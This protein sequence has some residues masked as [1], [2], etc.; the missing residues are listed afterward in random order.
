MHIIKN[1][2]GNHL[3]LG[4][5]ENIID[6][7]I[8]YINN[9]KIVFNVTQKKKQ[10]FKILKKK[11]LETGNFLEKQIDIKISDSKQ[12]C[13]M[14]LVF[15]IQDLKI[16]NPRVFGTSRFFYQG[17]HE[18]DFQSK[19][20]VVVERIQYQFE[21]F[22]KEENNRLPKKLTDLIKFRIKKE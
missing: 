12:P 3:D 10:K 9:K 17:V 14:T 11:N 15:I 21:E 1:Y 19:D 4:L 16:E 8:G 6:A 22:I 20:L 2:L 13:T 5:A 18:I 7:F